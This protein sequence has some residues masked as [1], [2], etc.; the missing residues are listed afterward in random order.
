MNP[1]KYDVAARV[2]GSALVVIGWFLTLHTS[3]TIG[4]MVMTSG[5]LLAVP[6]FIKSKAW[7]AVIMIS[8]LSAVTIHKLIQVM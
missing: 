3:V 1:V 6:W 2:L 4:A 5:D 7:D 8:F